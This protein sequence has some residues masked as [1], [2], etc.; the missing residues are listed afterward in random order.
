MSALNGTAH[1]AID[2]VQP[3]PR[4]RRRGGRRLRERRRAAATP[5]LEAL[6][7]FHEL[8][9][10]ERICLALGL[11]QIA[12]R[13]RAAQLERARLLD[14][15]GLNPTYARVKTTIA[16]KVY[17]LD[18]CLAEIVH[19]LLTPVSDTDAANQQEDTMQTATHVN[20]MNGQHP[21]AQPGF[22][23]RTTAMMRVAAS[24]LRLPT[25]TEVGAVV[26]L[27]VVA[28]T[29]YEAFVNGEVIDIEATPAA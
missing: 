11:P 3:P 18:D 20:E 28:Y 12:D 26:A 14:R 1:A 8:G 16:G 23:T 4:R 17:E 25:L 10:V 29:L 7:E 27:A 5:A 19:E 24:Q 6:A 21:L 22:F 13:A 9:D 2:E 15:I